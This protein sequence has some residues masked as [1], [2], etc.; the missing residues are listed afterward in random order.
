MQCYTPRKSQTIAR[1]EIIPFH[2]SQKISDCEEINE[3]KP[4]FCMLISL[5]CIAIHRHPVFLN[6]TQN[7]LK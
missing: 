1:K 6:M 4:Q 5:F 3:V 2:Y 7:L